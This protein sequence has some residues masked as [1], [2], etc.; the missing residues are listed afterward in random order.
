MTTKNNLEG[1][2]SCQE[3]HW[4]QT[5]CVLN[6]PNLVRST[7]I[8][9]SPQNWV[10]TKFAKPMTTRGNLHWI[11]QRQKAD[12]TLQF[13][14]N[15]VHKLV[16]VASELWDAF[17]RRHLVQCQAPPTGDGLGPTTRQSICPG[18]TALPT[19]AYSSQVTKSKLAS[20]DG[21]TILPSR[22]SLQETIQ[23]V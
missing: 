4:P 3:I 17:T 14:R 19:R 1:G 2:Y 22:A 12:G 6:F 23:I 18:Q 21:Q 9:D 10:D 16:V 5:S 11:L 13:V 20:A 15:F 8:F 7:K